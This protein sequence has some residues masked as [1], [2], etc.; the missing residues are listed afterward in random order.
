MPP[1]PKR[2]VSTKAEI[3]MGYDKERLN[4]ERALKRLGV[5]E[6][7]LDIENSKFLGSLGVDGRKRSFRA[8]RS[9]S[10]PQLQHLPN[11]KKKRS[12][13]TEMFTSLR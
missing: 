12:S 13:L 2:R 9:I 5:S 11:S 8:T 7:Q 10:A 3:L 1:A 6:E 4:R